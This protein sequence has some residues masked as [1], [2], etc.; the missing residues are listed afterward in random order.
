MVDR[1]RRTSGAELQALLA[2]AIRLDH[3]CT[4]CGSINEDRVTDGVRHCGACHHD[5]PLGP[6]R[7]AAE[8]GRSF[9]E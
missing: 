6:C 9:E 2:Q 3:V 8:E 7:R 4:A 1:Y 5:C